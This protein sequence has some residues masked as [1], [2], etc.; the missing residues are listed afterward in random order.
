MTTLINHDVM[1]STFSPTTVFSGMSNRVFTDMSRLLE[2]DGRV[3]I[4][5]G[6]IQLYWAGGKDFVAGSIGADLW[7]GNRDAAIKELGE[8]FGHNPKQAD[9][10]AHSHK[11]FCFEP[12]GTLINFQYKREEHFEGF[13]V[14]DRKLEMWREFK[15]QLGGSNW[16]IAP[17]TQIDLLVRDALTKI[18][19]HVTVE[20]MDVVGSWVEKEGHRG[21]VENFQ[22]Y[23]NDNFFNN[24]SLVP[25]PKDHPGSVV[26]ESPY[27]ATGHMVNQLLNAAVNSGGN[28]GVLGV[29]NELIKNNYSGDPKAPNVY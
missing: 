11:M 16:Q 21:V 29:S 1:L 14:W 23:S 18:Q 2:Q 26:V 15:I 6:S 19:I 17:N 20:G 22:L 28:V 10:F 5:A 13:K 3:F 24:I 9:S 27:L 7:I 4:L 25:L 8:L 12:I